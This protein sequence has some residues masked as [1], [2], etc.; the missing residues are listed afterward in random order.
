[1]LD[2]IQHKAINPELSNWLRAR[3]SLLNTTKTTTS[4]GGQIIDWVPIESQT[5]ERIA[6][7]P[8]TEVRLARNADAQKPTKSVTFDIGEAGPTQHVPVLRPDFSKLERTVA[9]TDY[10]SK[11]GGLLVN[12]RRTNKKPTDPNPAGYFH[13]SS[14]QWSQ[15]YGCDAWLNVWDPEIDIPSSPGDDHSISQTWIQNYQKP[16]LQSLEAGLTVDKNLNGDA[17]NHIF[18]YYTTNGY[19]ADGN[20]LGGYN[21]LVTG[22]IQYHPT[23]YPG[24]RV[25]GSSVQGGEQLEI[26]V[27]YQLYQ[28]NWWFGVNNNESGPWIWIG[29]YP[30]SLFNGGLGNQVDWVAF[31]GEVYTALANPCSTQDQM[32]SGRHA[33]VGWSHAAYQRNLRNQSSPSGAMVNF[34]GVPEV[35]A[36]ANNCPLNEFTIQCFMDSGSSW[37]SYQY[38]GGPSA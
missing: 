9:L 5:K 23:I 8:P 12:I 24:I 15:I 6:T 16:E 21:R 25:N 3:Q 29:Y 18:T 10:L 32:G 36:A 20:N 1:M 38:Y 4:P 30:A 35:D 31:G 22:W 14:S 11:R 26:A 27:K 33:V 34:N 2:Q 13:A 19:T 17:F 28:G 7:P 37:G